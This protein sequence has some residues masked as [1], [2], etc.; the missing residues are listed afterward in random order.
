MAKKGGDKRTKRQLAPAF[1][2]IKRKEG[3]FIVRTNP[4]GHSK[5]KSYP[6]GVFLRDVI[7]VVT[8]MN[9]SEKVLNQSKVKVDGVTRYDVNY[10]V[11]LMDIVELQGTESQLYRLVPKDSR[12]LSF[13]DIDQSE[14]SL[15]LL[16]IKTKHLVSNNIIQYGFHD[17]KTM[18]SDRN[19]NVGDTVVFDIENKKII[20]EIKIEPNT[21]SLI[22]SGENAGIQGKIDEVK[23]GTFS[24]P[25]RVVLNLESRSV[26]LPTDMIMAIGKESPVIKVN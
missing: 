23:Q 19:Y 16:K 3:Q 21:L 9:E 14:K 22:I 8:T 11:G 10:P 4:G 6:L 12:I 26:E 15:K 13:I 24:I 2:D 20:E 25:R 18:L 7:K 1:W 17:G 5:T